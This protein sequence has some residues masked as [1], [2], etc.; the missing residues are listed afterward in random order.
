MLEIWLQ[1]LW[2]Q[3]IGPGPSSC[4]LT[5]SSEGVMQPGLSRSPSLLP[6]HIHSVHVEASAAWREA[7]V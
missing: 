5:R 6:N 4:F 3:A 2:D 1:D 7:R